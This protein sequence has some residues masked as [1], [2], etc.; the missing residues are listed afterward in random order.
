MNMHIRSTLVLQLWW[1]LDG[2]PSCRRKPSSS[3]IHLVFHSVKI[4]IIITII[5][6]I[7]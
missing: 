1:P 4:I 2:A 5:T 6:V 3:L 7:N